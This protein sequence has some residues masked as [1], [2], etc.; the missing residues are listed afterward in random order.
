MLY[1]CPR[2]IADAGI[3]G[4]ADNDRCCTGFLGWAKS[5]QYNPGGLHIAT[6][7]CLN[8][9]LS[10]LFAVYRRKTALKQEKN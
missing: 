6:E 9:H 1:D 10:N 3:L 8:N 2:R 4:Q 7:R 5:L